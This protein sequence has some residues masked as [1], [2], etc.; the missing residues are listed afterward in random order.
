[1]AEQLNLVPGVMMA[2]MEHIYEELWALDRAQLVAFAL[3]L[4]LIS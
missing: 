3:R 1:M 4:G 2:H